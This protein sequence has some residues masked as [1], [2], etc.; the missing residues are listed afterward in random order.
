MWPKFT[1]SWKIELVGLYVKQMP[2]QFFIRDIC[3]KDIFV[4]I[5]LKWKKKLF[6]FALINFENGNYTNYKSRQYF[7]FTEEKYKQNNIEKTLDKQRDIWRLV[8]RAL[9][10]NLTENTN[11]GRI[12]LLYE[13][14]MLPF[15][16][17]LHFIY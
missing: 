9:L 17:N 5:Y 13:L 2:N 15:N 14:Y 4:Q 11:T 6:T 10:W 16:K 1:N 12:F 3:Q 7:R 8:F